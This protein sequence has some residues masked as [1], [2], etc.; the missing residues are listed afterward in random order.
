MVTNGKVYKVIFV[1]FIMENVAIMVGRFETPNGM[2]ESYQLAIGEDLTTYSDLSAFIGGRRSTYY[3]HVSK[4][5]VHKILK[6]RKFMDL[7]LVNGF[8]F[9]PDTLATEGIRRLETEVLKEF[10][11]MINKGLSESNEGLYVN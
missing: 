2:E 5:F 6:E 1:F 10:A 8:R 9:N 7:R 4:D 11:E 3:D